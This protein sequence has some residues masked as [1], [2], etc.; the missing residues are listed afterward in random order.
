[1]TMSPGTP[2]VGSD[3]NFDVTGLQPWDILEVAFFEPSGEEAGWIG[4]DHYAR[5]W[6]TN[7]FLADEN[8][9]ARWTRYG[10]QDQVR[11]WSVQVIYM[12][13]DQSDFEKAERAVGVEPGWEAGFF[14]SK[15]EYRGIFIQSDTQQTNLYH[16]LT[17][18]YV[19]FLMH[20][21]ARRQK[22]PA[23]LNEGLAG[24][25]EF[26][27]GSHG[28]FPDASYT[29]MLRSA[30]RAQSAAADG[31][32]LRLPQLESQREWNNRANELVPLQYAQS[33]MAVR[34]L[35]ERYG[36]PAP[37][38]IVQQIGSGNTITDAVEVVTGVSFAQFESDFANWLILWDD[39]DRAI[40]QPYLQVLSELADE[41]VTIR[42][43]R[44][45]VVRE[46]NL[47]FNRVKA[48]ESASVLQ[49]RAMKLVERAE[50]LIPAPIVSD[51]HDAATAYLGI[52][53]EWL[54][55]DLGFLSTN[56][57]SKRLAANALI[58][59]VS[60]RRVDFL[61]RLSGIRFILNLPY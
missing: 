11:D 61:Q 53:E 20:E 7:Y 33:H 17:H 35:S 52:L 14:Q 21:I 59:E 37:I 51:L 40:A 27:V 26:E 36:E 23:W 19:H 24:Y 8:G 43:L 13:G 5:S 38:R 6:S 3:V 45:E 16:A 28:D 32:L 58:P 39:P 34:Y 18:E 25:Y 30:D 12:L 2:F 10:A 60:Y 1:M 31:Q 4:D 29:R 44:S 48:K 9:E 15:G 47:N 55:E 54:A 42:E 57:E 46:W 50:S 56:L 22:L 41:E 49:E